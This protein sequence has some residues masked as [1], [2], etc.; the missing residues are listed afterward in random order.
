M[1]LDL[2]IGL[3]E[4]VILGFWAVTFGRLW[5]QNQQDKR[6]YA[7][8]FVAR[9]SADLVARNTACAPDAGPG[10]ADVGPSGTASG[11]LSDP[12]YPGVA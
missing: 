10:S 8:H 7:K 11:R 6:W 1:L 2:L 5:R 3:F 9:A 4:G 12:L